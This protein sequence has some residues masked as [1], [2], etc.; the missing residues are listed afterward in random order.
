[1]ARVAVVVASRR[2]WAVTW[3][4][5]LSS[6]SG[7]SPSLRAALAANKAAVESIRTFQCRLAC[8]HDPASTI[9]ASEGHYWRA[10]NV[11]RSRYKVGQS[12]YD[13]S[14]QNSKESSVADI[15]TAD[16]KR[17]ATGG[18]RHV[19]PEMA[20]G[21][22]DVWQLGMLTAGSGVGTLSDAVGKT[23]RVLSSGPDG[24][25]F[26]LSI[27]DTSGIGAGSVID[28][29]L[30]PAANYLV[31]KMSSGGRISG[32]ETSGVREVNSFVEYQ[33]GVFFPS[34]ITHT[35]YVDKNITQKSV[36]SIESVKINEPLASD[37]FK[38]K[39]IHGI[40]F[41]DYVQGEVYVI[42]AE[43]RKIGKSRWRLAKGS[44]PPLLA[45]SANG[46]PDQA[47]SD[48]AELPGATQAEPSS[49]AAWIV[50]CAAGVL[51]S[52]VVVWVVRRSRSHNK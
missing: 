2:V 17:S 3:L 10:G 23:C 36:Y 26:R 33:P 21:F 12:I 46:S 40:D 48:P 35:Q 38:V 44:Q 34:Q 43:G 5:L 25:K 39:Y 18:L 30:D 45:A 6:N 19:H 52:A 28:V 42:D 41:L 47:V 13:L 51:I 27:E 4:V 32:R 24:D 8:R 11:V 20:L 22:A 49:S 50:A 31:C 7:A 16:G 9:L 15:R 37:S 1:M 14:R 29:W